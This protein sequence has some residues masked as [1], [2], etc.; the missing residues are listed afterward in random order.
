M[1]KTFCGLGVLWICGIATCCSAQSTGKV[2]NNFVTELVRLELV[3][4]GQAVAF[5]NPSEGW[6][7][8]AADAPGE[9]MASFSK[10]DEMRDK[11]LVFLP[12]RKAGSSEVM[13]YLP[14]GDY[15]LH[16][17]AKEA[18]GGA[19]AG[20]RIR[21]IPEILA[22]FRRK[23]PLHECNDAANDWAFLEKHVN[24][25]INTFVVRRS[26]KAGRPANKPP[27]DIFGEWLRRGRH[28]VDEAPIDF[29]AKSVEKTYEYYLST[30]AITDP[31]YSGYLVDEF[32]AREGT[33]EKHRINLAALTQIAKRPDFAGKKI[34]PYIV[35]PASKFDDYRE[36]CRFAVENHTLLAWEWYMKERRPKEPTWDCFYPAAQAAS[37]KLWQSYCPGAEKSLLVTFAG[38]N[39]PTASGD[40]DPQLNYKVFLDWQVNFF[41][42][43]PMYQRLPGVNVWSSTYM[44]EELIRWTARLYRHYCIEG[45][46]ELLSRDPYVLTHLVNA[47]FEQGSQGWEFQM[48]G[49][50]SIR[51]E[52]LKNYG[53]MQGRYKVA[54]GDHFLVTRRMEAAPNV[55]RQTVKGLTPGRWY[56]FRMMTSDYGDLTTGAS[57]KGKHTLSITLRGTQVAPGRELHLPY[58]TEASRKLKPFDKTKKLCCSNYHWVLFKAESEAA[59]LAVSDWADTKRPGGP[60]GQEIAFN[61]FQLEPYF[62][63]GLDLK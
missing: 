17:A 46:R 18:S 32:V 37:M 39:L 49:P 7:Y 56:T 40:V 29:S 31:G 10:P 63:E 53:Q 23:S 20:V 61:F 22:G 27:D 3:P 55:I 25:H 38:W 44:D 2:L 19:I 62:C 12:G 16:L 15:Q 42:N 30:F 50:Q 34:Y 48:A 59:E 6:I 45:N 9:I 47:D 11:T 24:P 1:R 51:A 43:H 21:A 58:T 28:W 54:N 35:G 26:Y 57:H 41:A 8:I 33:L 4:S 52:T 14:A 5:R 60:I 36:V 13:K